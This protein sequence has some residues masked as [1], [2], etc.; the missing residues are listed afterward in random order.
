VTVTGVGAW[1]DVDHLVI[2]AGC[3]PRDDVGSCLRAPTVAMRFLR[4]RLV[5]SIVAVDGRVAS[6][7]GIGT[8][9]P[10]AEYWERP[11]NGLSERVSATEG[12]LASSGRGHLK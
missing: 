8:A 3:P 9:I 2:C 1:A 11:R 4:S 10:S 5:S 12:E 7:R 6:R